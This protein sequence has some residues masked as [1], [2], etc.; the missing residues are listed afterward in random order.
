MGSTSALHVLQV[1]DEERFVLIFPEETLKG[2]V[3]MA[4]PLQFFDD[5]ELLR[6]AEGNHPESLIR[7]LARG[8]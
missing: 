6:L 8:L 3:V 1:L 5:A 4:Q 7:V 2:G